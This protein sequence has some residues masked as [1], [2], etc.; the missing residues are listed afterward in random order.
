MKYK[1]KAKDL[2]T[3][4]WVQGDLAYVEQRN[5]KKCTTKIRPMILTHGSH[6]GMVWVYSRHYVEE[7]TI[8]LIKEE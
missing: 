4:E 8:E 6:G 3:G 1:F 2:K 7:S 5:F